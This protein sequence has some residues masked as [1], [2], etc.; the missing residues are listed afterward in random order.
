MRD[1]IA[2]EEQKALKVEIVDLLT[3][4]GV[5]RV[6]H[7]QF[8]AIEP[9][10]ARP[11]A[12][13]G[14]Q[15]AALSADALAE[16]VEQRLRDVLGELPPAV[17]KIG[18]PAVVHGSPEPDLGIVLVLRRDVLH[19]LPDG[20]GAPFFGP[21]CA[22]ELAAAG[23]PVTQPLP[24][25]AGLGSACFLQQ[26]P[27]GWLAFDPCDVRCTSWPA[28]ENGTAMSRRSRSRPATCNC[29]WYFIGRVLSELVRSAGRRPRPRS[30]RCRC[31]R[32]AGPGRSSRDRRRWPEPQLLST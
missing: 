19:Q 27:E 13:Q 26:V 28:L 6:S 5:C 14:V 15:D 17:L 29:C 7:V 2:F 18:L 10:D 21:A 9:L 12:L 31:R 22:D 20:G 3:V 24:I 4:A 11:I 25:Q 8:F 32:P 30:G 16:E 1:V 23:Q